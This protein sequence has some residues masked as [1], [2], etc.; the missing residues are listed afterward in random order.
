MYPTHTKIY[1]NSLPTNAPCHLQ[2]A[3]TQIRI[4]KTS[5]L[6]CIQTVS[7]SENVPERFFE[8]VNFYKSQQTKKV[9]EKISQHA[10]C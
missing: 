3:W 10:K 2:T 9:H 5:G 1:V 8:K 4:D 7:H 6:I